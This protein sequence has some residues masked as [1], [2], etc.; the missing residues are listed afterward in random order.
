MNSESNLMSKERH[1][2]VNQALKKICAL[3][4]NLI[5]KICKTRPIWILS[6][7][8]ISLMITQVI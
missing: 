3:N 5:C 8:W 7:K 4:L 1:S 6:W 2:F